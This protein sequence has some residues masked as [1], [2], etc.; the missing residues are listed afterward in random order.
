MYPTDKFYI[1]GQ[2]VEPMG[3][4]TFT[5]INPADEQTYGEL[6]MGNADDVERA[7]HA[8][9][10][11]F[12]DYSRW[13]PGQRIDLLERVLSIYKR[14][15][16]EFAQAM[17]L[18]MGAPIAFSRA[19]QAARG[20]LHIE[21]IIRVLR[22]FEFAEQH[23]TTQIRREAIGV[24]GLIT[25][26]NW[27]INQIVVKIAPA[28]AAGCTVVLKPSEFSALS[29]LLFAEVLDEAGV[30]PG[31]FNLVNGDGPNVGHAISAH[32]DIDMVS[33]T[34]S[35][36]AGIRVAK[37]AADTVK[38]VAQELGGK[39]ANIVLGDADFSQAVS[40]G[41]A[42]C[43][44]NSGQSCSIPTRM[45]VPAE[46]M[47]DVMR[48]ARA[49]VAKYRVGDPQDENTQLGPLVNR[50]QFERVQTLVQRGIDEGAE[51][52]CGGVGRPEGLQ[53]G[54]YVQPTVFANVTPHMTI[55]QEEI[56]GPVLSIIAYHNESEA[57]AIA[58]GTPYGL[59]AY[60]QSADLNHARDMAGRLRAGQVHLNYPPADIGAPFGGFKQ[61]G[62]GREWGAHG[63]MEY[64]ETKA[65]V[66]FAPAN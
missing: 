27:P 10:R 1:D 65:I 48:I 23:G 62:N 33:F 2:W 55:A 30:P 58:N 6:A 3:K 36:Q 13:T 8:A 53:Q 9:R 41:I 32:P 17:T 15:Y 26:W 24:C 18:E 47:A 4:A 28:L 45:L 60:V 46:R 50:A 39:S 5:L 64:L 31:V 29:A 25:P 51:L 11:A 16:E 20:S 34:G 66:G 37:T 19:A 49:E 57:I 54:Y 63:L 40:K 14:R 52:V 42:A 12:A 56:F 61:S 38:R 21:E 59:A 7:V 44:T 35:T 43:F 22:S